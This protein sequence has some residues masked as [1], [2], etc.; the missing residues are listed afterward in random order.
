MKLVLLVDIPDKVAKN[1]SE[2]AIERVINQTLSILDDVDHPYG[3]V[4]ESDW[5]FSKSPVVTLWTRLQD[6]IFRQHNGLPDQMEEAADL[7]AQHRNEA[8]EPP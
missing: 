8:G 6:A 1:V 7:E 3:S 5:N 2:C 4:N